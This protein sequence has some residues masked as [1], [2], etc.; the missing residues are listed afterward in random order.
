MT[1]SNQHHTGNSIPDEI[2]VKQQIA[3]SLADCFLYNKTA[4][5]PLPPWLQYPQA[6]LGSIAWRMGPGE[7][8]LH[9]VFFEFW[10]NLSE[11]QQNKYLEK[12]DLGSE[13]PDRERWFESLNRNR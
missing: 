6:L 4:G 10:K 2:K 3:Q 7:S 1:Q 5:E 8:Y 13:W 9:D 12:F 11:E